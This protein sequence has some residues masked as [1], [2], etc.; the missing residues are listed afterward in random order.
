MKTSRSMR[1]PPSSAS[2]RAARARTMRAARSGCA[3]RSGLECFHDGR[4][5]PGPPPTLPRHARG[6]RA[7]RARFR[8]PVAGRAG[9]ETT[10]PAAGPLLVDRSRGGMRARVRARAR[11]RSSRSAFAI[12]RA[13]VAGRFP[14]HLAGADRLPPPHAGGGGPHHRAGPWRGRAA[15][16]A[17]PDHRKEQPVMMRSPALPSSP[18]R[19]AVVWL[20][21]ALAG[22]RL[23]AAEPPGEDPIA[24]QLFPPELVMKHGQEIGLDDAQRTAMKQ[25]IQ[26]AQTRFLDAQWD[27]QAAS[28]KMVRLLQARPIDET[29]VLAQADKVMGL[30]R[31]VKKAQLSLLIRIKNLLT[32]AQ[33]AKLTELR[34]R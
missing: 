15:A 26:A 28:Q 5:R 20:A 32:E 34:G 33:Q 24:Q 2:P 23:A 18:R 8:R 12:S 30:E 25:A 4:R 16:Q 13:D 3:G 31:D 11:A 9:P 6:G 17:L 19:F 22:V 7:G 14:R 29:T 1:P 27:M 21:C 10:P